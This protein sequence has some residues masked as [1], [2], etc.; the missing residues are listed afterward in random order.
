MNRRT[1]LRWGGVASASLL[2]GRSISGC[3][4]SGPEARSPALADTGPLL[5]RRVPA[6]ATHVNRDELDTPL[7][8]LSG[9][10]PADLR[11][12]VFVVA[13]LP[14]GDGTPIFN[15]DGTIWRFDFDDAGAACK[16]R[17]CKTPCYWADLAAVGTEH[18]F[19]NGSFARYSSTLGFRNQL[20]TAFLQMKERLLV[21]IDAGRPYEIDPAT[22]ELVS[23]VG[24]IAEW[25][26]GLPESLFP[27]PFALHLTTAHP[28]Y[29]E[30]TGEMITVNYT[31]GPDGQLHIVRWDGSGPLARS[32]VVLPD[33]TPVVIQQSAHQVAVSRDHVLVMDTAFFAE[34]EQIFGGTLSKAQAPEATV[35]IVRRADLAAGSGAVTA[36]KAVLPRESVHFFADYDDEG[37]RIT[38]HTVHCCASDVSEWL[39][40]DDVR[41]DGKPLR[42]DLLGYVLAPTD[43]NALGRYVI[44]AA[45]GGLVEGGSITLYDEK[46]W[47]LALYAHAG[48]APADRVEAIYWMAAGFGPELHVERMA[49]LYADYPH[50]EVPLDEL[51]LEG[52][53]EHLLR[54]DPQAGVI[55]DA[56]P[57]PDG[58]NANSPQFVPKKGGTGGQTDGYIVCTV[59][60]DD[61]SRPDSSGDEIWIFDAENL[62]QG[63]LCRLGHAELD[64]PLTLHTAFMG[65][66]APAAGKYR[67]D[68]RVDFAERLASASPEVKALMESHVFPHFD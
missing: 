17:I 4:S 54:F 58:R 61:T 23:P 42:E 22:L 64:L 56:Y 48:S 67:I 36:Q 40:E 28:Y 37:G 52:K 55:A 18:A 41:V 13:A 51:P 57:F 66:I 21:T 62:A 68:P 7:H 16:S 19:Q 45:T 46:T 50:R 49:A 59:I 11:G 32:L 63:P 39:R 30:R 9:Q 5:P 47:A 33:G 43:Q 65:E 24:S 15:G 6:S 25:T 60:S 10:L 1:F 3:G 20:N 29:D 14:Y 31:S 34:P 27:G 44:D 53:P 2:A 8:V 12:H 38:V 26:S 35:Y